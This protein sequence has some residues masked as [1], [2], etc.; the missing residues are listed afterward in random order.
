MSAKS[1][2]FG[3]GWRLRCVAR[4]LLLTGSEASVAWTAPSGAAERPADLSAGRLRAG[5]LYGV[6]P[7]AGAR[8]KFPPGIVAFVELISQHIAAK[9]WKFLGIR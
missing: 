9:F 4:L 1:T 5:V 6:D 7:Y 8:S 2:A 3:R